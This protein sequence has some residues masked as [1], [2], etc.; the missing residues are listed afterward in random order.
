MPE[1][2]LPIVFCIAL[3]I[4]KLKYKQYFFALSA[5]IAMAVM[6]FITAIAHFVFV[7]GMSMMLPGII[8]YKTGL[9]YLTGILEATAA[10]GL[11]TS[12][13]Y[14]QTAC[15][16]IIF[17]VLLLPANIYAAMNHV[18]MEQ[19]TF[20]GDGPS[21]LWYRIP[22]QIGFIIWAYYSSISPRTNKIKKIEFQK[23]PN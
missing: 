13:Y 6:L 10:V 17:F 4:L 2:I 1:I 18:D 5:R 3:F 16:L 12:K 7:K 9:I 15:I 19:G 21:Y 20:H 8:P 11:I 22:L 14:R 23:Y